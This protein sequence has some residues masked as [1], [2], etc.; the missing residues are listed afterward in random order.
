[1]NA[2]ELTTAYQQLQ[3][4]QKMFVDGFVAELEKRA[5]LTRQPL[6]SVLRDLPDQF[7][8]RTEQFLSMG[9]VRAAIAERVKSLQE[10]S[11]LSEFMTLKHLRALAYS[12]IINY[13]TIDDTTGEP[14]FDLSKC[15]PEQ[16]ASVKSIKITES[17][18]GKRTF[19]FV[20]HDKNAALAKLLQYQGLDNDEHWK[21]TNRRTNAP[22]RITNKDDMNQAARLYSD[23]IND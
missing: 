19:E 18:Q 6:S 12:N 5:T 10:E 13:M 2:I 22:K 14:N 7:D 20:L 15:T 21:K 11:E 4:P 1:M 3:P 16:M 9:L 17:I 23:L 8:E